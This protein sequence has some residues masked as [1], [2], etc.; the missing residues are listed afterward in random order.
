MIVVLV[1]APLSSELPLPLVG[2]DRAPC[3]LQGLTLPLLFVGFDLESVLLKAVVLVA[4]GTAH[5]LAV[6]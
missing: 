2:L 3:G 6:D 4:V 1:V 5:H